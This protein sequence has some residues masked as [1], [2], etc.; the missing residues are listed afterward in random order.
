MN[1][2]AFM[3]L[4]PLILLFIMLYAFMIIPEKKRKK[5]YQELLESVKLGDK[6][7]TRGGIHGKITNIDSKNDIIVVETGPDRMRITFA[8]NAISTIVDPAEKVEDKK[9]NKK[10]DRKA[11]EKNAEPQFKENSE[12]AADTD[13]KEEKT[14]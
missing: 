2:A 8:K 5:K 14:E 1:S 9:E 13:K 7:V 11:K 6:I 3:Q 12:V 4:M 10:V